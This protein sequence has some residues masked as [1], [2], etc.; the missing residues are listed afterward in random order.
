MNRGEPPRKG[1]GSG[2]YPA[3]IVFEDR[4]ENEETILDA[5]LTM[6]AKGQLALD[7]W[8]KLHAAAARD[9]R[10]SELAFAYES[11]SQGKR[12]KTLPG[13]AVAEFLFQAA[14]FFGD[15]FAD[16]F[17]AI[18]Y[19][20]RAHTAMPGHLPAFEKLDA[21]LEKTKSYKRLAELWAEAA[22]QRP[23]AEQLDAY[24]KAA[25]HF[26]RA[27]G[28]DEKTIELYQQILRLDPS[29]EAARNQL[30]A[31][32]VK[33][34]RLR[35]VARLLE[36]ALAVDPPP[37]LRAARKI[38][39]R[40]LDLYANQLH[41]PE[42]TIAH[43][44]ALLDDDA[45]HDD[46]RKVA[47]KLIVI[48]GIAARA[49]A[50]LAKACAAVGTPAEVARYLAIELEH[51]RGP[52]RRDVLLRIGILKQE[53]MND[54]KGAFESFEQALALDGSDD[55]LRARYAALATK[56]K[57]QL[58]AAKTLNKVAPA[59]KVPSQRA[60]AQAQMGQL[61][62][63]GGDAKRAKA[64]FVGVLAIPEAGPDATLVAARA[65][66]EIYG[67][68]KDFK[69]LA[70]A[71][72]RVGQ[73]EPDPEAAREVNEQLAELATQLGDTPRA[74]AAWQR[75]VEST[76]RQ[77]ALAALEPLYE[78][79]GD[80]IA[81]ASILEERSKDATSPTEA[82]AMAFKAG[83]VRTA[84]GDAIVASAAWKR[85]VEKF[86]AARDV[87]K[88]WL[89]LLEVERNWAELAR[90]LAADA[91]LAPESERAEILA[92][93]GN[94][95]LVRLK[96]APSAI[97]AFK[98]AL[99]IDASDKASRATLEKLAATGEHRLLAASVLEP[100]YRGE[101]N[102]PALLRVLDV[103]AS[104]ATAP[105]ER[106]AALSEAVKLT[107]ASPAEQARGAE[108]AGRGLAEAVE[109]QLPLAP[110]I[111]RVDRFAGP[112]TDPKK[113]AA[114]LSHA[115]GD[116]EVTSRD[117]SLL[118]RHTGDALAATGDV[119]GAL[120]AFRRALEFEPSSAELISR[121]DDLLRDQ[122]SPR[123]RIAL[124]RAA[125]D[126]GTDPPRRRA[127]LHRIGG[128]ERNDL[129]DLAAAMRT[130]RTALDDDP[131]DADAHAALLEIYGEA[132][133]WSELCE[134]LDA[135]LQRA[136]PE[137]A[138]H[139]RA[140][141]ATVAAA[142]GDPTR[143]RAQCAALLGDD[144]LGIEEL[145]LIA[146]VAESLRDDEI[147]R[148]VLQRRAAL[149][150]DPRD[151]IQW[152]ERLGELECDRRN[153]LDAA[154]ATW[155]RAAQL[156]ETTRDEEL[157][158][159][160]YARV[161]KIAPEDLEAAQRLAVLC[162]HAQQWPALPALYAVLIE[163]AADTSERVQLQ[164]AIAKVHADRLYDPAQGAMQAARAFEMAPRDRE[165]LA[166]F[167]RLCTV[168]A[169][170]ALFERAT[171]ELLAMSSS[172][173]D[174]DAAYRADLRLA[175]ARVLAGDGARHDDA[176]AAY[177]SLLEV[178]RIDTTRQSAALAAFEG[179]IAVDP[180][181]ASRRED[182]RW[183]LAWR[184]DH[185][186]EGAKVQALVA[187]AN[188]EET[189]FGDP[190]RALELQ[191]RILQVDPESADAMAAIA[192]LA[193]ALGDIDGALAALTARRD[194]CGG[195]EKTALDLQL[196]TTI[197]DHTQRY[198]E[199]LASVRAVL[200]ATP[201]D[202]TALALAA[203][204][205]A[206]PSTRVRTIAMLEAACE[207]AEDPDV[208]AQILTR[209]LAASA[210][211][212]AKDVATPEQR[213]AWWELLLDL[214]QA[215]GEL[216]VAL[217]VVVRAA[218]ELPLVDTLWDRA[219]ALARQLKRPDEVAALYQGVLG[220]SLGQREGLA[221]GERAVAFYEEW[222]EDSAR[223]VTILERVLEI[224][225]AAEW[226]FDRLKL[227]FDAA[228]RWD[229]LF[230]LFDRAL[231]AASGS[232]RVA[233]LEDAAQVAKDFAGRPDRAIGYL[234]Q[235]LTLKPGD[236]RLS[237]SLERL[238]ERQGRHRELVT[239]LSA[240]L[241]ALPA[242]EARKTRARIA[243]L[244]I[245]ELKDAASALATVEEMLD[246]E[247][248][249]TN[250]DAFDASA[251]IERILAAAPAHIEA[252][253]PR[254]SEPPKSRKGKARA[255]SVAPPK[256]V[257]VRQ[258]AAALLKERYATPGH[259]AAL[260][261]VL[262][263]ELEA[264]R[265]VKERIRRH[266][267]I[268]ALH[269]TLGDDALAMEQYV[270]LVT[271][272]PDVATHR[273]RLAEL[274]EKVGRFDRLADV[275]AAAA[276]EANDDAL[277]V[278]LLMQAGMVHADRIGDGDRAI[279]L[280]L[281][282]LD[283]P[284]VAKPAALGAAKRVEPL[285]H[286]AARP[287]DRLQ[288]IERIASLE[289]DA[290]ARRDAL[291]TVAR[292]ATE[293]D[294][295]ERAIDAWAL[296]LDEDSA[297]LDALDGLA[298][299]LEHAR[300]FPALVS[301][302]D[303]RARTK[304]P[305]ER[306]RADRVR[307]A[308]VYSDELGDVAEAIR[309]WRE[310]DGEFGETDQST[311]ALATLLRAAER[312]KDLAKLLDRGAA[313]ASDSTARAA[314]LRQ[315]GDVQ[316]QQLEQQ[317]KAVTS[318]A[319]AL[320]AASNDDGARAGLHALL[321][322]D[323][324]RAAAVRVLMKTYEAA[325]EWQ[326][327]LELTPHR[328]LAAD[329]DA[330]RL[331]VLLHAATL[332]EQRALDASLAFEA[333][334]RAFLLAP[335]DEHVASELSRLAETTSAWKSFVDA[336]R[337]AL[338]VLDRD[339]ADVAHA[340]TLRF[341]MSDALDTR[342]DDA[343]SALHGYLRI[344]ADA[345]PAL[346]AARASIRVGGK[347][348]RWD[349]VAKVLVDATLAVGT[350]DATLFAA[351]EEAA[352][353]ATG[354]D[355]ITTALGATIADR[356]DLAADVA[357]DL[358]AQVAAWHRD[359]RGDPDAAETAFQRALSHDALHAPILSALATLQRRTRGRPLVDSL[360]RLSQATGGDLE[361]LRE[362]A[363]IAQES[364]GDRPLAKT[365]LDRLLKLARERWLGEEE[366]GTVTMGSPIAPAA[367]VEWSLEQLVHI[368][369]EEG[370]HAR[371]V[372]LLVATADLPFSRQTSRALRHRA[373]GVAVEKLADVAQGIALYDALF[374]A[375]PTDAE[376]VA[377]LIALYTSHERPRDLLALR[378]RQ[379]DAARDDA[380]RLALRLEAARLL[381]S[382][383]E[384]D[385]AVATLQEN[386]AE[387]PH[388]TP[389]VADLCALLETR[390]RWAELR[391]LYRAQAELAEAET[392]RERAAELWFHAA[393]VS[394]ERLGDRDGATA[395][396]RAV[397]A[398]EPRP[399]SF[400]ALARLASAIGDH[401]QASAH[402]ERLRDVSEPSARAAVTLRLADALLA[403]DRDDL[404]QQRL[405]E[406]C[407]ADPAAEDV[408]AR[409]ADLYRAR[410]DWP[411]LA[412]LLTVA[413]AHAPDK[414]A[415][416]ARLREGALLFRHRCS[417]PA[418]A[419]PLLEQA[420]DLE[421]NE[422][423]LRLSLADAL[424]AAGRFEEAR[425]LLKALIDGFGGRRPKERAPV[426]YQLAQLEL[427][428]G[429]RARAL[430]E[431]DAATR[432]DPANPEIL[433]TLA[434]LA[435]EDGQLERAE[436]SYRALLVVLRRRED[437]P[438]PTGSELEAGVARSEVLLELSAI[439][440][441]QG[442][443]DRAREIL[444]SALEA[445][446]RSDFEELRLEAALRAR[447]DFATLARALDAR[448]SRMGDTVLPSM[449]SS[450]PGE[451]VAPSSIAPSTLRSVGSAA[452]V[453]SELAQVLADKLDRIDDALPLQLRAL[454]ARSASAGVHDAT[455]ALARRCGAIP[456]YVD[457]VVGLV[458]RARDAA[459]V[460]LAS[461]LLLRLGAVVEEDV[462][463][464][465][466]AAA[467]YEEA[468]V[469]DVRQADA[470]RALDRVHERRRDVDAQGLVLA[471]L[472][473]LEAR[474]GG[475]P[476][477][478]SD[479][480]YRLAG[481]RLQSAATM[482]DGCGLLAEAIDADPQLDRAEV[483]LRL[484]LDLDPR[485]VHALALLEQVGRSPGHERALVDAL[486][487]RAELPGATGDD[488][489][490]A[491]EI[492]RKLG[493]DTHAESLL[494]RFL[495]AERSATQN[496]GFLAWAMETLATLR[497]AAGDLRQ[498]VELKKSAASLA[499]PE[500]SRRLSF[501]VAR[502][503][504]DKLADL[505]LAAE[506]YEGLR[507][508]D[509]ADRE[510]WEPLL[511]VYRRMEKSDRLAVLLASVV[512]FVDD[513]AE[514]S[515]LRLERVKVLTSSLGMGED[516]AAAL[517]EIVDDDPS[518]VEAAIMLANILERAGRNDDLAELL[519][520]QL[521]AAKDRGDA[522][523]V[524]SLA[525]R[526]GRILEKSD[527]VEA[528]NVYYVGLDWD[529][530]SRD[531]LRA[532]LDLFNVDGEPTDRADVTERLLALEQGE[533]AEQ[534][535]LALHALRTEQLDDAGAERA[536]ELGYKAHPASTALRDRLEAA[537]RERKTWA[538]L[539][540]LC[541]LDAN[542]RVVLSERIARLREAASLY[543]NELG[544]PAEGARVLEI[545]LRARA[546]EPGLLNELVG[547][548][549]DARDYAGAEREL[550]LA[551]ERH[552]PES[553]ARAP[554]LAKR[555]SIQGLRHEDAG[556]LADLEEAYRLSGGEHARELADQL[557][558]SVAA[559]ANAGDA[560]PVRELRLRLV[561]V[562]P[563]AGDADGA[564]AQL[565][566]MV[567]SDP[568]DREALRVL[569]GLEAAAERW[570]AASAAYRRLVALE[571]GE[572]VVDTALKL[573]DA[574][575]R[576]GRLGDARGGLERARLVAPGDATLRTRLEDLYEKTG[577]FRELA[578]LYTSDARETGDVAGRFALLVRAGAILL[579]H[580]GDG[581]AAIAALKEAQALRPN[582]NTGVAYLAD[583][584]TAAG[585]TVE[586]SELLT[587]A[588]TAHKGRR[589]R[590]LASLLHR[591][592]RVAAA[593]GEL[594]AQAAWLTQ[595]L[596][597]D[598]QN[599]PVASELATLAM[600]TGQ[601]DLANRALRVVTMLKVPGPMSKALAYQY[602]GEIARK[603][604]DTKRAVLLLKRAVQDDPSLDAARA[605]L[606]VLKAE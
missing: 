365:I 407:E 498:A 459:D 80:A 524:A 176:A 305:E 18:T 267:Q 530:Q 54:D 351:V 460:G 46:A 25:E 275:L 300:N 503:A 24:R 189:S 387:S 450:R 56:L 489:R 373:A 129:R 578:D 513:P 10:L 547:M 534:L 531:L 171:D 401:A 329:D 52:K 160:L 597:M 396:H 542:A 85:L 23:R 426:H 287:R 203:R 560:V 36:Q 167:E 519:A 440:A 112:G 196:A 493:D 296:R 532:L 344:V 439:A 581:E 507:E 212:A 408:R 76:S 504:A 601:L 114:I 566:E 228:E 31:R 215:R 307:I 447:S 400:D 317:A 518:Q 456:R 290:E 198:D 333:I 600:D 322:R 120:V 528:R 283:M 523:S 40:L 341:R 418:E 367:F 295:T 488:I 271:L 391:D 111:E 241:P 332:S 309:A 88:L 482:A 352:T 187:W 213:R 349:A 411:K 479:A 281:R 199:A 227:L 433:R 595:A 553:F 92:R 541:V 140:Q 316:A 118:A 253:A 221:L 386:L 263:V 79:A 11:V 392:Q 161:R 98:R 325:D 264:V 383:D 544:A 165:V 369:E 21:L 34:N 422:Q 219:E 59:L 66:V 437:D 359:R 143:A 73:L 515:R 173:D 84:K 69:A 502:I 552:E 125:L 285:L 371:V 250:G 526:L 465:E 42:R 234:E 602:M 273:V 466:R 357:R 395:H 442:S 60:M 44:E 582:D 443:D 38:H 186:A 178:E 90:A 202:A 338:E 579:E 514:R 130:Y 592:A 53:R 68:E 494:Q 337:E 346:D 113:R 107:G 64:T 381:A 505:A 318:Y 521:D 490:E 207:A 474:I 468:R 382:L 500:Q 8:D 546:D 588:V 336:H 22:A 428:M 229:D 70:D 297:D 43:V 162:E 182:A 472:V 342:L 390:E 223:V 20:E 313:R 416:L 248:R 476:A 308:I 94:V 122:G 244:W 388:H 304:L 375:D 49:A 128:I 321:V 249:E 385:R 445:A 45:S 525:L 444:E 549:C 51:T 260:V 291:G 353:L 464:D 606:E 274:A 419:V 47:Q 358:E 551:L 434:E 115:L 183:L 573:A 499:E 461:S 604:G 29:D 425:T 99:A 559:A 584:Y 123:E 320:D 245:D 548:L 572:L 209:L 152:L 35:D 141:L 345:P 536:L 406:A 61:L 258:R 339:G 598:S 467:I 314:L 87:H 19:L 277:R 83:E 475:D 429:N 30:E 124:H 71:L 569:A 458:S 145:D 517:R 194:R 6:H 101:E 540:E 204:L 156:A 432:I 403:S 436:R 562:L 151:Q 556:A 78:A 508:H 478:A 153:D 555:A 39:A 65:L 319:A 394:E 449:A 340:G 32:Y 12:L 13:T 242:K 591:L 226:A 463:D 181:N 220:Q 427:A 485:N 33:A 538:K 368:H 311:L 26:E 376:A 492:A 1:G 398:L 205:L 360:L 302:L 155:K 96:D 384:D 510:A 583:A 306:R 330:A 170:T 397:V 491:I 252:V 237:A 279:D 315:L 473:A 216:D 405:E 91:Q 116:R 174:D 255:D 109:G 589:S 150:Q 596:D 17:G 533:A 603:Q 4:L 593:D 303:K 506:T 454:A 200:D 27:A 282:I 343:R 206:E 81:L 144:S 545:A 192:R 239:L 159:Q 41:E 289:P 293:L 138:R 509:P 74:I 2:M 77:R 93:L 117:L 448:L 554:L 471:Q 462:R 558:R 412:R 240:R 477:A 254:L 28:H 5:M 599:G 486:T 225:P 568:K 469:L 328:L 511:E 163:H 399:A 86:G 262:E 576:A 574:C 48:K 148:E 126:R 356:G 435:R 379:I 487:R 327:I 197:L 3:G 446:A 334:R 483:A 567:K 119:T 201:Q 312:W 190:A 350:T 590:E 231:P 251:L 527:R 50:A 378:R 172:G 301:V 431:L 288:V 67:K 168:S 420:C 259:E 214:H 501:E 184:A 272:E 185:A 496:V 177:R 529:A 605:L 58:D 97:D 537:Y 366:A 363:G 497:E 139:V 256:R 89:P 516:A 243:T 157:A 276:E 348:G 563:R 175:K 370:E 142:H 158:R 137:E 208:R 470:L 133:M 539:A 235:L 82:R 268:A 361:L 372:D 457:A 424:G 230:A 594:G 191:K 102:A 577:A 131:D 570:D 294:E 587:A 480:R 347:L 512:E 484:A 414:A 404:A 222:F 261:R 16:E 265:S 415:R 110:W 236:V 323:D 284:E 224:D 564:R 135:R 362:A 586:A 377:R 108:L 188:A 335:S 543:K 417:A 441:R 257:S 402:L 166:V 164:I 409:L 247:P 364:I 355:A 438:P 193:L 520:K 132:G 37:V 393:V 423:A 57:K 146:Q 374:T 62:L 421:P 233:L 266:H 121:V 104:V 354:W 452:D 413:A 280:F 331:K 561:S 238:Y 105:E 557:E 455:L 326:R 580:V 299:L 55:E 9:E 246:A 169:S 15:T 211:S 14:R 7:A 585:R 134:L 180:T 269:A 72:E 217:G 292:L 389:T 481:L 410:S 278:E 571:E 522:A 430:V 535:A 495:D 100:I 286:A 210:A 324:E 453:L 550:G 380:E 127:L 310:V 179:L 270:A 63:E 451:S 103:R 195:P 95:L 106:L 565:A 575:E 298:T 149:S 232:K 154:A 136:A 75:L 218:T 147:A